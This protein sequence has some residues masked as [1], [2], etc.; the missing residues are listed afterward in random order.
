MR[1]A[2]PQPATKRGVPGPLLVLLFIL[3]VLTPLAGAHL[4]GLESTR[5][6]QEFATAL[7]LTAAGLLFLQFLSSGRYES[8]SG[9][10]GID[11]T[12]VFTE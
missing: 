8:V 11:R 7:G 6:V 9:S 2:G 3:A 1:K 12:W 5:E 4:T 10:A